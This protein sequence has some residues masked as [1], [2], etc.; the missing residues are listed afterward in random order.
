MGQICCFLPGKEIVKISKSPYIFDYQRGVLRSAGE[1][2]LQTFF[3]RVY[4]VQQ[5]IHAFDLISSTTKSILVWPSTPPPATASAGRNCEHCSA[6]GFR[7]ID[8]E[9][10]CKIAALICSLVKIEIFTGLTRQIVSAYSSMLLSEENF[11]VRATFNIDMRLHF[12]YSLID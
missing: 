2:L 1:I 6:A 11:P 10:Y 3:V 4:H 8:F 7:S 12:I 5:N 9:C